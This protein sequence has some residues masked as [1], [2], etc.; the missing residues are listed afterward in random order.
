[1]AKI[2]YR[3][4]PETLTFDIVA[5]PLK[6][7]FAKG[8]VTFLVGFAIA[9]VFIIFV[10]LLFSNIFDFLFL[11]FFPKIKENPKFL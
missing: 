10:L 2:Q 11:S 3:F 5:I 6:T 8:L 7:R 1:M 9:S 4:N